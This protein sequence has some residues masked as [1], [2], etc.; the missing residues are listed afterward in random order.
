VDHVAAKKSLVGHLCMKMNV[1]FFQVIL[2][3]H[4]AARKS[5][6]HYTDFSARFYL[7]YYEFLLLLGGHHQ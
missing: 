1:L 5:G 2:T 7:S 3:M 6:I 4:G